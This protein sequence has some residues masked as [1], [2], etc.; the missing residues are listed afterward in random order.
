[1]RNEQPVTEDLHQ[2]IART[3]VFY[4]LSKDDPSA[5][6]RLLNPAILINTKVVMGVENGYINIDKV[7]EGDIVVFQRDF[8]RDLASYEQV[9]NLAHRLGKPT[10]LD[11]DDLLFFLPETHPDKLNQ[12][13]TE[14]LLPMFQAVLEADY[15]TVATG[16]LKETLSKFNDNIILL[17]NYFD[18]SIWRLRNVKIQNDEDRPLVIG[19]MGSISHIPDIEYITQT[20]CNILNRYNEKVQIHFWGVPPPKE[21]VIYPQ[22][23]WTP[24]QTFDYKN[25]GAYF[26]TQSADIFIAP[27]VDNLFNHAK[28]PL[29]FFEY[30]ALGAPGVYSHLTPYEQVITHGQDGFLA[31]SQDEWFEYLCKLIDNKDLRFRIALNAQETVRS[32]WLLSMNAFQWQETYDQILMN[33]NREVKNSALI[34]LVKSLNYQYRIFNEARNQALREKEVENQ[35]IMKEIMAIKASRSWKIALFFRRI[36]KVF[37]SWNSFRTRLTSNMHHRL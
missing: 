15:V 16:Q 17:P 26:Q 6:L 2:P 4:T 20:L 24:A 14:A 34:E 3:I 11:L 21:L 7:H 8:C 9:Q 25:F 36:R 22:V 35:S 27:L 33:N 32:K 31:S 28:S 23:K 13:Y 19:Y 5:V 10:I 30:T 12:I 1:M 29:K 37:S 18:D